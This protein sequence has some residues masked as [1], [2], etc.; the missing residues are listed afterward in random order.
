MPFQTIFCNRCGHPSTDDAQFCQ[1]C[2]VAFAI[3]PPS[4]VEPASENVAPHYAGFWIRVVAGFLDFM[5]MF[6]ASFPVKL[7]LGSIVTA[8]GVSSEMPVHET[9]VMRRVARI[10]A[11]F[12][13]VFAYRVTMESSVFQ[14]TLGKLAVRLKV[15][16]LEGKRISF[17]RASGRYFAKWLSALALGLGYL[18]VAFDNQKQGLHDRMAGT[19]VL[20]RDRT[21]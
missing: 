15:T 18:M 10:S 7:L 5:L 19:L 9:L 2:G 11:G 13:L 6:V 1:R 12:L 14:A 4:T 17:G 21:R 20:Y 3:Q 8:V 16:D